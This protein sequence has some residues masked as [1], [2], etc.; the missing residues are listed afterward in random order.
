MS[1]M[2]ESLEA[3]FEDFRVFDDFVASALSA[4]NF[5]SAPIRDLS[6]SLPAF[7]S[8][9]VFHSQLLHTCSKK[10]CDEDIE[11]LQSLP[12]LHHWCVPL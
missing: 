1:D 8:F 7:I 12:K 6:T 4:K 2:S 10:I 3:V 5:W 9:H 11:A